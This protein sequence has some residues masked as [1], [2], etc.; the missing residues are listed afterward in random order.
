M[1]QRRTCPSGEV[2]ES[3]DG[4]TWYTTRPVRGRHY[5]NAHGEHVIEMDGKKAFVYPDGTLRG[6]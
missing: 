5:L 2:I 1:K 4:V 3:D 6:I